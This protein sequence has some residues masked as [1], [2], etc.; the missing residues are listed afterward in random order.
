M[1]QNT[2]RERAEFDRLILETDGMKDT[3]IGWADRNPDGTYKHKQIQKYFLTWQAARRAPVVPE[4]WK[5]VPKTPTAVQLRAGYWSGG[6]EVRLHEEWA[7]KE[8]Y[9]RMVQNAPQPPEAAPVELPEPVYTM[10]FRGRMHDYT[11]TLSAFDLADG[12]HE[13]YTEQQ[14]RQLLAAHDIK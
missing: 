6:G 3:G 12:E 4:G 10:R 14:V 13:L 7:R 1:T 9:E 8:S 11:P 5:L 2:E